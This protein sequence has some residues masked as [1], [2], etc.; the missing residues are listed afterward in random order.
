M[1]GQ[2]LVVFLVALE[3]LLHPALH[4][5]V[6]V[7][8]LTAVAPVVAIEHKEVLVVHDYLRVDGR[9][10]APTERQVI[11]SV[12]KVGLSHAVLPYKTVDFGRQL[13]R[14]LPYVLVVEYGQSFQ[15]H[16]GFI[17]A[18]W[19]CVIPVSDA[20]LR[21]LSRKSKKIEKYISICEII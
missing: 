5:A 1:L 2:T 7:E 8:I 11:D 10:G 21:Q 19:E 15:N 16:S 13:Y 18:L 9:E 4:A 14:C 6:D 3:M 17:L 12:E 20:K